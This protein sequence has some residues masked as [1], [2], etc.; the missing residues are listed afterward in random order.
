MTM[1]SLDRIVRSDSTYFGILFGEG[2]VGLKGFAQLWGYEED[3]DKIGELLDEVRESE[4]MEDIDELACSYEQ[5]D[6]VKEVLEYDDWM[7]EEY[8]EDDEED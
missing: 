1:R 3:E 4:A 8:W 5:S 6:D 2:V 7:T